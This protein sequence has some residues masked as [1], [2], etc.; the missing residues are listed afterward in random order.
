MGRRAEL[1]AGDRARAISLLNSLKIAKSFVAKLDAGPAQ[2]YASHLKETEAKRI[3]LGKTIQAMRTTYEKSKQAALIARLNSSEAEGLQSWLKDADKKRIELAAYVRKLK[4]VLKE[5]DTEKREL[6]EEEAGFK[7][8]M[9][10]TCPLCG[11]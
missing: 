7:K 6:A 11:R 2:D 3:G 9:P 4:V 8:M 10:K 5:R 1:L